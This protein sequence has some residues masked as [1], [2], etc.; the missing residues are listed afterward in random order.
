MNFTVLTLLA[1][2]ALCSLFA[3][4]FA[5][6]VAT[7]VWVGFAAGGG[8]GLCAALWQRRLLKRRPEALLAAMVGGF[9]TKLAVALAGALILRYAG[10]LSKLVDWRGFL[11]AFASAA[12]LMLLASSFDN[13]RVLYN[14]P[15]L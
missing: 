8:L 7:G 2:L 13:A 1:G 3:G 12:C 9:L 11:V 4:R 5:E 14:K 15:A 6:P 10:D